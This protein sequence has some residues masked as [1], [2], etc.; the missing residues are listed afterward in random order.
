MADLRLSG[1]TLGMVRR[2]VGNSGF[3]KLL[4]SQTAKDFRIA[5]LQALPDSDRMASDDSARPVRGR[6]PHLWE[7]RDLG[8]PDRAPASARRLRAAYASGAATPAVILDRLLA[9]VEAKDFGPSTF[10]PFIALDIDRARQ[11]AAD[12]T[13]RWAAKAPLGPLDGIPVPVK[14]EFDFAGLPTRGGCTYLETAA[15]KDAF[16]VTRLRAAGAVLP[17]KTH[18]TEWG[19]N[20]LGYNEHF[21]MPRNVYRDDR[22]AG[23]SSTGTGVAMGLGL[24]PVGLGSDG[25]GSIRIPACL[26]GVFGLKPTY[27][28]IGRTGDTWGPGTMPHAGPLGHSTED[29]VDFLEVATG[30]DPDDPTSWMA[31]DYPGVYAS[32]RKALGRGV[33][34]CRIGVIRSEFRDAT[35]EIAKACEAAL[36]ALAAEGAVL[37]DVELPLAAFA[38][39]IG[40]ITIASESTANIDGLMRAHP[41]AHTDELRLIHALLGLVSAREYFVAARTRAA[42]RRKSAALLRTVDVLALPTTAKQ[43]PVYTLAEG[44]VPLMD[45]AATAGI[46]RFSFLGNTT[47][48]PACN[49]PVGMHDGLPIGLQ[50]VGDAWDEASVLAVMAHAERA[51]ITEIPRSP[52]FRSLLA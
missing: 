29:L 52:G 5:E 38:P 45:T 34:G 50:F 22:G 47:G 31:D 30:H 35:P 2:L 25:G 33:R 18:A 4:W 10:S 3:R 1:G 17:G 42:L 11:A 26:N 36:T 27:I 44:H 9:R 8:P 49:V 6:E 51:G 23:G 48:L 32:W 13:A 46:T 24:G 12:S 40:A 43:A 7:D 14:D 19:L 37:V 15:P 39:A 20:P 16:V 41:D 28:R 21:D